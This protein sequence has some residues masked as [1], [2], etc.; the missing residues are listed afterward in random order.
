MRA[1]HFLLTALEVRFVGEFVASLAIH[2]WSRKAD[3]P[4]TDHPV[5]VLPGLAAGNSS[6]ILLR[7]YLTR[8]RVNV[9]GWERGINQGHLENLDYIAD[10]V[11]RLKREFQKPV[12]LVGWS[13]GGLYAREVARM[14]AGAVNMVITLGTPFTGNPRANHAVK[15]VEYW[16]GQPVQDDEGWRKLGKPL[17]VPTTSIFSKSDGIVHW[18]TSLNA[19]TALS[20]NICVRTSHLGIGH[21]PVV[22]PLVAERLSQK[23]E[24]WRAFKPS[25]P[26]ERLLYS[27]YTREH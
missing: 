19:P 21:H 10:Q 3:T 13:M 8:Q 18:E 4:V 16:T 5:L 11:D 24:A 22:M 6:T 9:F 26:L 17:P 27:P 20:E 23:P 7:R 12:S 14:N 1:P 2:P 15:L 25:T